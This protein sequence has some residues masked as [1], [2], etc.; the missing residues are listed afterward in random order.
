M[1]RSVMD[2]ILNFLTSSKIKI[3]DLTGGAPELHPF[4]RE[5]VRELIGLGL[6]V[7]DRCNL[8]VLNDP[9]YEDLVDFFADQEIEI[10]A[11]LPCYLKENVEAQRGPGVFKSSLNTLK[12]L[13]QVGYGKRDSGLILNLVYNPLGPFLPPTQE[14]LEEEYRRHLWEGYGIL[15]NRLF[16]I[17]NMPI[18]RFENLLIS[19]GEYSRYLQLLR[20][21]HRPENLDSVMCRTLISVDWQGYLYD[22]DFNQAL[23]LP[24]RFKNQLKVHITELKDVTLEGNPIPFHPHCYGCTAGHGSSCT[25]ALNKA[26]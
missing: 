16:T 4:F 19:Q 20:D 21:N 5:F 22:C 8:T 14:R 13:N 9:G 23:D 1:D 6:H 7:I 25:G 10:F 18:R 17:T 24:L 3:V 11:S 26:S 2:Q 12:R 15:F